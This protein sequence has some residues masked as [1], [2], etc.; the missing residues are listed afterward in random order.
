MARPFS[1]LRAQLDAAIGELEPETYSV[2]KTVEEK[3]Y[4]LGVVYV[5]GATDADDE[6]ADA[7]DLQSAV[8]EY[9]RKGYRG[10]RDTHTD[11]EIGELVELI[12]W[13]FPVEV[14]APVPG[15]AQVRKYALP[16]GSVFAGVV[17]SE[18]AW[19]EAKKGRL[20]GFSMGGR[21]VRVK[22]AAL[23]GDLPAMRDLVVDTDEPQPTLKDGPKIPNKPGKT[24]WVEEAGG[25]PRYIRQIAEDLIDK[26]GVSGA[27]RLAVGIVKRWCKGG[28]NVTAKTRTKACKAVAEWEEKKARAKAKKS[29]DVEALLIDTLEK[30]AEITNEE[31]DA[32]E[33]EVR[34]ETYADLLA[35][36]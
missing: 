13:P 18:E 5:P 15:E 20:R 29:L 35:E 4:T 36:D 11:R 33:N 3:R 17:W 23:D 1:E 27:I 24:N 2:T 30:A 6:W 26:H 7:D 12:S 34:A 16:A 8:W 9:M 31:L 19:A 10:I 21:A 22:E 14:E 28:G 32:A 25:L